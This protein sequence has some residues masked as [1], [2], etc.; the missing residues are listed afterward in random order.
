MVPPPS[1]VR[2][3]QP[4]AAIIGEKFSAALPAD[5]RTAR[6]RRGIGRDV[7]RAREPVGATAQMALGGKCRAAGADAKSHHEVIGAE[8]K[9]EVTK[10]PATWRETEDVDGVMT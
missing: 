7:E 2:R 10:A 6:G 9:G 1:S 4:V 8:Y 3:E 5:R